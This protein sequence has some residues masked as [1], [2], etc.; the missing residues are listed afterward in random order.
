MSPGWNCLS[1]ILR[2]PVG[3]CPENPKHDSKQNAN[4]TKNSW[5]LSTAESGRWINLNQPVKKAL[6]YVEVMLQVVSSDPLATGHAVGS[7]VRSCVQQNHIRHIRHIFSS[8][9]PK[10]PTHLKWLG[11][12]DGCNSHQPLEGKASVTW[13]C[14]P[15]FVFKSP[16]TGCAHQRPKRS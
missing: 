16:G 8:G 7:D 14:D 1:S 13:S 6:K 9:Q 11:R 2:L 3:K 4:H 15:C 5:N 12:L 10:N